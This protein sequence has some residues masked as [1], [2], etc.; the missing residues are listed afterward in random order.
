MLQ[1]LSLRAALRT[2]LR[3]VLAFASVGPLVGLFVGLA[4]FTEVPSVR[5]VPPPDRG[6]PTSERGTG[7]RGDCLYRAELPPV[8][9]LVGDSHLTFTVSDRP[10]IWAYLPY[11]SSDAR[12]AELILYTESSD[13]EIYRGSFPLSDSPGVTGVRFPDSMPPLA[14]GEAYR[15]Y[16]DVACSS[17]SV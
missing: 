4:G 15:W 16:I 9:A 17:A 11:T 3:P 5:Y 6:T 7:S 1:N 8:A 2:G 13:Q 14:V 12:Y 10:T